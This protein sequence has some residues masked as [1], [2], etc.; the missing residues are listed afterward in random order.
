MNSATDLQI[1]ASSET[2]CVRASLK[3][4]TFFIVNTAFSM[5]SSGDFYRSFHNILNSTVTS[6]REDRPGVRRQLWQIIRIV[7]GKKKRQDELINSWER[8]LRSVRCLAYILD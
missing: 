8:W 4:R 3:S 2:V 5:A 7:L 1:Y 6:C